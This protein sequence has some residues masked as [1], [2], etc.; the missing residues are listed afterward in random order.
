MNNRRDIELG[1]EAPLSQWHCFDDVTQMDF[2]LA[3]TVLRDAEFAATMNQRQRQGCLILD[4]SFHELGMPLPAMSLAAAAKVVRADYVIAPDNF[5]WKNEQRIDAV[6]E[7]ARYIPWE[8]IGV[9]LS[10][11]HAWENSELLQEVIGIGL[12]CFPFK[13]N[14]RMQYRD[15]ALDTYAPY[16]SW[17]RREFRLIK[18]VHLL[19]VSTLDEAREW[20]EAVQD[21]PRDVSWSIDTGKAVKVALKGGAELS[22]NM[23]GLMPQEELLSATLDSQQLKTALRL[24]KQLAEVINRRADDY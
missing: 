9:V 13:Q 7:L 2:V 16:T 23:R 10:S 14:R 4:N 19:G 18:R 8:C 5:E 15:L 1:V 21:S 3:H 6:H 20:H 11:P 12:L 24:N 17:E 22:N